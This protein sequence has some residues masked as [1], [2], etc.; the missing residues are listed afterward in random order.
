LVLYKIL[1]D[2]VISYFS[3]SAHHY[4][5]VPT[6]FS[7]FY[8]DPLYVLIVLISFLPYLPQECCAILCI[9]ICYA[10]IHACRRW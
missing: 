2:C 9:V 3:T 5:D 8:R 7:S 10:K 6:I 1:F 4:V